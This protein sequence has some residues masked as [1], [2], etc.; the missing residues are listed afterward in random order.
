MAAQHSYAL[1]AL[2]GT[3]SYHYELTAGAHGAVLLD[4]LRLAVDRHTP[5]IGQYLPRPLS[6]Q[7]LCERCEL[8]GL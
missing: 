8:L 6:T 4:A 7:P 1:L 3:G 5:E 2:G